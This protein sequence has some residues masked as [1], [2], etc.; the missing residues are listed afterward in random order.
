M[1]QRSNPSSKA[2]PKAQTYAD[3]KAE[4]LKAKNTAVLS[5]DELERIKSMCSQTTNGEDYRSMRDNERKTLQEI[6]N[7]RVSKWP[8][9]MAALREKKEHDRI[10][11]LEDAEVSTAY[12]I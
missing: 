3:R 1:S 11:K 6:S 10:K 2:A 12:N 4:A 8:N 5:Y 9:T 7:A